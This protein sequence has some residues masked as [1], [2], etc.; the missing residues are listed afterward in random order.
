MLINF[1]NAFDVI[2]LV[3]LTLQG[4][5]IYFILQSPLIMGCCNKGKDTLFLS[6]SFFSHQS[7]H[8]LYGMSRNAFL[9]SNFFKNFINSPIKI[10]NSHK[11]QLD[12]YFSNDHLDINS[13]SVEISYCTFV[14]CNSGKDNDGGAIMISCCTSTT[15]KNCIFSNCSSSRV[16]GAISLTRVSYAVLENNIFQ[17]NSAL[18]SSGCASFYLVFKLN[19]VNTNFTQNKSKYKTGALSFLSSESTLITYCYF[20]EN[21]GPNGGCIVF[22]SG[23]SQFS[24]CVFGYNKGDSVIQILDVASHYV[25][26][27]IFI[28]NL[29]LSIN[30]NSI[31]KLTLYNVSFS[32]SFMNEIKIYK[33]TIEFFFKEFVLFEI[34]VEIDFPTMLV[35]TN[36]PKSTQRQMKTKENNEME[37]I[38]MKYKNDLNRND[39]NDVIEVDINDLNDDTEKRNKLHEYPNKNPIHTSNIKPFNRKNNKKTKYSHDFFKFFSVVGAFLFVIAFFLYK[40]FLSSSSIYYKQSSIDR[41]ENINE[42][43]YHAK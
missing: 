21:T 15:I 8:F 6:R 13:T 40:V 41:Q 12:S 20:V 37:D 36:V 24:C 43:L 28:N 11:F 38:I 30:C 10:D 25:K 33:N 27:S 2:F 18:F 17:N 34:N 3:N 9:R 42:I 39:V 31:M 26:H 16:G 4:L 5:S 14:K 23:I 35:I 29:C 7:S 32:N 19:M 22:D 1:L